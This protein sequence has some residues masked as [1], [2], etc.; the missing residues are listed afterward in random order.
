MSM[1]F[2]I[3]GLIARIL[4]AFM[5]VDNFYLSL[6]GIIKVT[7]MSLVAG[8]AYCCGIFDFQQIR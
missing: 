4:A 8:G 2:F 6:A 5:S 1:A 7:T 3:L